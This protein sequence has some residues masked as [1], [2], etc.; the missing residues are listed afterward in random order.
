LVIVG[1]SGESAASLEARVAR[2]V[3]V[4]APVDDVRSFLATNSLGI[5]RECDIHEASL[6]RVLDDED[7]ATDTLVC[8]ATKQGNPF[9]YIYFVLDGDMRLDQ[10]VVHRSFTGL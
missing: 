8:R 9:Y 3:S 2:E 6:S 7:L 4:G 10:I 1:C 5:G